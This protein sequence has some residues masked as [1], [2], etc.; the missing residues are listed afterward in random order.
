MQ[1]EAAE[2]AQ[3]KFQE[4]AKEERELLI[5]SVQ[6]WTDKELMKKEGAAMAKYLLEVGF[7]KEELPYMIDHRAL[8]MVRKAMLY[9]RVQ[10]KVKSVRKKVKVAPTVKTGA[11]GTPAKASSKRLAEQKEAARTGDERAKVSF[12]R[13][14]LSGGNEHGKRQPGRR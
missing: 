5:S 4:R 13:N 1:Q 14:L 9:D 8:G 12:V 10:P 7:T 2:Q 11:K 6:E 3:A